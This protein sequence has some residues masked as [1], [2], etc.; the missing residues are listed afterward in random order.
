MGDTLTPREMN[1]VP[2]GLQ[3]SILANRLL[4]VCAASGLLTF[5]YNRFRFG[6]REG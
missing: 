5:T 2:I 6:H 1:T 4:W 3:G